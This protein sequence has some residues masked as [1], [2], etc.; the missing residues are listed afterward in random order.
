MSSPVEQIKERL[1][2]DDVIASYVKLERSGA[3]FKARCPFHNEKTP[4]FFVS[5]AR[6]SYHCFGCGKGGDIFSFVEDI[7]GIDFT[8]TL[9]LLAE[10]AGVTLGKVDTEGKSEESLL[11]KIM[12]DATRFY[13]GE[14]THNPEA[15]S[16]LKKRGLT[17]ETLKDFRVGYAPDGW[18][19]LVNFL[20]QKGVRDAS[21]E[22]AGL[23]IPGKNG[24]YDRF[25][26]RIMFP[27]CNTQG[28]VVGFSGRIFPEKKDDKEMAKYVNSPETPLYN[29]SNILFGY[30]KAKSAFLKEGTCIL[31]EGQMDLLMAHQAGNKNTVAASG[32]ALTEN[33]LKLIKRFTDK[34]LL[35]FDADNA[36]V[37]ASERGVGLALNQGMDVKI[38]ALPDGIDPADA[39]LKDKSIWEKAVSSGKHIVDFYLEHLRGLGYDE[40]TFKVEVSKKVLPYVAAIPNSIEQGHFVHRIAS[41][42]GASEDAVRAELKKLMDSSTE[43]FVRQEAEH[44]EGKKI[45]HAIENTLIGIILW[46]KTLS[47]PIVNI[48]DLEAKYE[49]IIGAPASQK[50]STLGENEK[51]GLILKTE[52][53]YRDR[54]TLT[55]DILELL[56]NLE[57]ETLGNQFANLISEL[58][59]A[60]ESGKSERASEIIQACQKLSERI[61][62]LKH[63]K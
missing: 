27:I 22:K 23:A 21:I 11:L 52:L 15:L 2:I 39:I 29:K 19:A 43:G 3:Y 47:E 24:I 13:E 40:R 51:E 25:R 57:R 14:I 10:R 59:M 41:V 62:S 26:G 60:E 28:K 20:K 42:I 38:I 7:E 34:L 37:R 18:T 31:V 53:Y 8:Q 49:A 5:P 55:D 63:H 44:S 35:A 61:N 17:D 45:E 12:E 56:N 9:K 1:S 16:Y 6:G 58:R 36:G 48:S 54:T 32:T 33:H 46:Q 30:D 4:S 50:I